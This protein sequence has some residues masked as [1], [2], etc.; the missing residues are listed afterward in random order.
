MIALWERVLPTA[1]SASRAWPSD[2]PPSAIPPIVRNP[3]RLIR[4]QLPLLCR[5]GWP[6]IV[7]IVL[8]LRVLTLPR[9]ASRHH[10]VNILIEVDEKLRWPPLTTDCHCSY[11]LL[12]VADTL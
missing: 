8:F 3:R 10:H 4:S 11:R 1:A 5:R 9:V 6:R 7:S 2:N 12:S